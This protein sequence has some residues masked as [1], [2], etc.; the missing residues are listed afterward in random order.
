M[1]PL[2]SR[3]SQL[4][5]TA[6]GATVHGLF[7][8][9]VRAR[10]DAVAIEDGAR[11][12]SYR[13]LADRARRL[14]GV[15]QARGLRLG[16]RVAIL[17]RNCA[18]YVEAEL[19]CA[20]TGTILACQNWRLAPVELAHC[21]A[22]V[23][24][25]LALVGPDLAGRLDEAAPGDLAVLALGPAYEAALAA[26]SP[27]EPLTD[28]NPES[29]LLILYTS[30]TTGLPKGALISHRA[31]VA[32]MMVFLADA[33]VRPG[34][35]FVAWAPMFHMA[36]SDHQLATLMSGGT[37]IVMNGPDPAA[38]VDAIAGHR[39]GWLVMMP[40]PIAAL[41]E[42][43]R[44]R[45]PPAPDLACVGAMADL[46]ARREIAEL[47]AL[48]KAP[49]L[50]S[51]GST[52]TGLPPATRAMIP[53][54]TTDFSLSKQINTLVQMRLVDAA[55]NDVA[56][57]E[58]GE[59]AVRGPTLFSGYW[60]AEETNLK[61]FADGWFRMG[62]LFRR[63]PDGTVDFVDRAKYMIK[64]GGE[65]IYPAEIERVLLADPRIE[66]AVVIRRPDPKWGEVPVAII[67]AREALTLDE[68]RALCRPHMASYKL[69][70][71]LHR[72]AFEDFP[73]STSGKVQRHLLEATFG[74]A[75]PG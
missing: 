66:E 5:G 49:Y 24:P 68:I 12:I 60:G 52:E 65:N 70:K 9:R 67:A 8:E 48:L 19:A 63:N 37:V 75:D 41:I 18:E 73:R 15:F 46:V 57:G 28:L 36:S 59:I 25:A 11:R 71:A 55:G 20:M 47:T 42:E 10:P 38:I 62:D 6:S 21:L 16:D 40:G 45:P 74:K 34:D 58:P 2:Q 69:P 43:L 27:A 33:R 14:A 50:N 17:A 35:A 54:G 4:I 56:D 51:F 31:E 44:R 53:P 61:D 1:N 30:G 64:S 3:A 32:R 72:I 22:L 7:L 13:E 26:A 23:E 29:G 39:I